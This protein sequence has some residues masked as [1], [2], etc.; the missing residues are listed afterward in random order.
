M[1]IF[2]VYVVFEEKEIG[3]L[4]SKKKKKKKE[5]ETWKPQSTRKRNE[6]ATPG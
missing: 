5:E 2:C 4:G 3:M 1:F 6:E